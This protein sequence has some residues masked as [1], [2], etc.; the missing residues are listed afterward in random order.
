MGI[1]EA[2]WMSFVSTIGHCRPVRFDTWRVTDDGARV[3]AHVMGK[4]R[5]KKEGCAKMVFGL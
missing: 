4:A 3:C 1:S 5:L 2:C